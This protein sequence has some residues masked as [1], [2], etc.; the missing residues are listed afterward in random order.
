MATTTEIPGPSGD[1][2]RRGWY[3]FVDGGDYSQ[4]VRDR[5]VDALLLAETNAFNALLPDGWSWYPDA[6]QIFLPADDN[7]EAPDFGELR[8]EA[9]AAV[10]ARYEEIET[11][12]LA[13]TGKEN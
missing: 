10:Q 4:E 3:A 12:V 9:C 2:E 8:R 11:A 13:E 1:E 5:L 7:T 6:E